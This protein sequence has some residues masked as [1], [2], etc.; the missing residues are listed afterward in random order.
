MI[1][2]NDAAKAYFLAAERC[3]EQRP[4]NHGQVEFLLVPA[5]TNRAFATEL[6]FKAISQNDG[7]ELR[8]HDLKKLYDQLADNRKIEIIQ[9]ID[10]DDE[11]FDKEL[12]KNANLFVEWRYLFEKEDI[13]VSW[14]FLQKL[15]QSVKIVFEGM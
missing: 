11:S 1:T 3:E 10:M 8:G 9:E 2:T 6:Y 13:Q 5:I 4:I 12:E 7:K 15:S 14:M